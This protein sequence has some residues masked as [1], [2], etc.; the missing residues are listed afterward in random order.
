MRVLEKPRV[1]RGLSVTVEEDV[2]VAIGDF[3]DKQLPVEEDLWV[4]PE[5]ELM[6]L[7]GEGEEGLY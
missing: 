3:L 6:C 5:E 7:V 4:V 1:E 2:L